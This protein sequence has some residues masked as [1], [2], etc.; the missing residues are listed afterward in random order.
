MNQERRDLGGVGDELADGRVAVGFSS[1]D[2]FLE[3]KIEDTPQFLERLPDRAAPP[4]D[5]ES[6]ALLAEPAIL[7]QGDA[8]SD[9]PR[10][11]TGRELD[12]RAHAVKFR[13]V[14]VIVKR[15]RAEKSRVDG[16]Q[17]IAIGDEVLPG[18]AGLVRA[19]ADDVA[20]AIAVMRDVL[21]VAVAVSPWPRNP[22]MLFGAFGGR[23]LEV[24]DG[25]RG[26]LPLGTRPD[27]ETPL[28]LHEPQ[29]SEFPHKL[30]GNEAAVVQSI[31]RAV[32]NVAQVMRG[33]THFLQIEFEPIMKAPSN[34]L[35][36]HVLGQVAEKDVLE[37]A[38]PLP[39]PLEPES[40]KHL[41]PRAL[42]D[43]RQRL[44]HMPEGS[45]HDGCLGHL[46]QKRIDRFQLMAAVLATGFHALNAA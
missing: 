14:G 41:L 44:R 27:E 1:R 13:G 3:G 8:I 33:P 2:R 43:E 23:R 26:K 29:A 40:E 11:Q 32:V 7:P 31:R 9:Q 30:P 20:V 37:H 15:C 34:G 39:T 12:A 46:V 38:R 18:I 36:R 17:V 16:G 21:R 25:A 5:A 42:Q 6:H 22:T 19:A 35:P 28:A 45:P 4:R 24:G 10:G